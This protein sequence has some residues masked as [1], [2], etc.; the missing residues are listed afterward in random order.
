M[1]G[2]VQTP[3]GLYVPPPALLIGGVMRGTV[4]SRRAVISG[5]GG[6]DLQDDIASTCFHLDATDAASTDGTSQTWSNLIAS[7]ADGSGQTVF[8]F[9]RGS[10]A[11]ATTDDPTFNGSAGDPG[12]YWALDGG[13]YFQCLSAA[14]SSGFISTAH[15]TGAAYWFAVA[16]QFPTLSAGHVLFGNISG[17]GSSGTDRGICIDLQSAG[18]RFTTRYGST[19]AERVRALSS[20][21]PTASTDTL[22]IISYSQA[23]GSLR[24]WQNNRTKTS[25]SHVVGANTTDASGVMR[26]GDDVSG[27][28]GQILPNNTRI[29]AFAGGNSY[30]DDTEAGIIFDF[31]NAKHGRTYA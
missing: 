10:N 31:F 30:I 27:G 15:R 18:W 3:S 4:G 17:G 20:I 28:G 16:A 7:P 26:L 14:T 21:T 25:I 29:Y 24:L 6:T 23:S 13:D 19:S 11:S 8:D 9:Y 1:Q 5:G 2:Y 12:A 22:L